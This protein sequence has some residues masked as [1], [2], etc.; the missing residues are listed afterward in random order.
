MKKCYCEYCQDFV[1]YNLKQRTTKINNIEFIEKY[2]VCSVC[3]S[4]IYEEHIIDENIYKHTE[5]ARIE[6]GIITI[7][8]IEEIMEKYNIGKKPLSLVLGFGEITIIRY[9]DGMIPEKNYSDILLSVLNNVE[10]M[11]SYLE[12]NKDL[13]TT[14]AYKK[15]LGRVMEIKLE[16]DRSKIYLVT[17]HIIAKMGDITPLALQK[18]LYYIQGFSTCLL[19]TPIFE[20]TA[21]AWVHGPVYKNIY[22]RFSNYQYNNISNDD[23]SS[24]TNLDD[25]DTLSSDEKKLVD[26][27]INNFGCYSGK[28]LEKM[29]HKTDPWI[30]ARNGLDKKESSSNQIKLEDI[31]IY[32]AKIIKD[33]NIKTINDIDSY[34]IKLFKESR[35]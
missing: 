25:N 35:G 9:L 22:D 19:D 15:A 12:K 4:E 32:F 5:L 3:D 24:Y 31:N 2:A 8:Q 18:I 7:S 33:N 16:E 11:H 27:I 14:V 28:I 23:F 29:T 34:V 10:L 21:E 13:I 1:D 26:S 20:D 17:K 30:Q 6:N